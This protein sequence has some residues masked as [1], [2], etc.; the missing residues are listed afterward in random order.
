MKLEVLA[1]TAMLAALIALPAGAADAPSAPPATP[2]DPARLSEHVRVLSS[3]DFQ[4]RGPATPGEAKS[5]DYIAKQFAAAGVQPGGD[6]GGWFQNV[7]LARFAVTGP[8]KMQISA[9]GATQALTQGDQVVVQ[10]LVPVDHV[11]VA[12]APLVFVGYG[13]KAPECK[14]D[15][16]KGVDLHGKIAVVLINDPDFEAP[17]VTHGAG[18]FGGKAMTYYG[19][20]TYKYEEA[21]RQGA[22]GMLIVH[23]TEPAAYGWATVKNS[24]ANAQFDIVRAEPGQAHPLIQGWLQRDEAVQL[25]RASGLDFEAQKHAAQDKDFRPLVLKDASFSADYAVDHSQIVSHNVVGRLPGKVR[26]NE[27]V[28]YSAHWD[29]LGVGEPDTRGDRIFNG[30]VDNATGVAA[31]IELAR[32]YAHAPRTDRSVLFLAVT[33]EEKGLL[34]SEYYATHPLYP[35]AKTVAELNMDALNPDGAARDVSTSGSGKVD[36]ED[37]LSADARREGRRFEPDMEL[38]KGHFYRS[39]HFSFARVGVPGMSLESGEDLYVGGKA[40][41]EAFR[42]DYVAHR[43]HQPADEWSPAWDLRGEAIDVGL[44]YKLGR[45]LADSDA[46]PQW[47]RGAEFKAIRDQTASQ[48]R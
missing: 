21:A 22:L 33:A 16:F 24:N 20:W 35:L 31:L 47:K 13:V 15:D 9:G 45:E 46:W 36:L 25:F 37:R 3:D 17:Q 2:I 14:W 18:C 43:Y 5:I 42:A 23:E 44:L 39:D 26:P 38:E 41:G 11:T 10:T 7:P 30:A 29:H 4:G 6:Q 27:T 28:I 34:G 48:R 19:R 8:V 12:H 1:A 40:A 32:T